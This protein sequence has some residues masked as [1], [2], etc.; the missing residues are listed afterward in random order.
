MAAAFRSDYN[1][2][3]QPPGKNTTVLLH[4]HKIDFPSPGGLQD[5]LAGFPPR[6]PGVH[7]ADLEGDR[8]QAC[9]GHGIVT[10]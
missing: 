6:R 10:A 4:Q 5:F 1:L 8:D 7:L 9:S 3:Y 2:G